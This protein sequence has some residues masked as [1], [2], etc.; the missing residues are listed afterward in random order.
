[1]K[2]FFLG[3]FLV[4]M[5][6]YLCAQT[7]FTTVSDGDWE[8]CSTWGT[9]PGTTAGIHYPSRTDDVVLSFK[10]T[11]SSTTDNGSAAA[12]PNDLGLSNVCDGCTT[13]NVP[14]GCNSNSFYQD[15]KITINSGGEFESSVKLIFTDT[16]QVNSG[17]ILDINDDVFVIGFINAVSGADIDFGDDLVI[18]GDG[19]V[20]S[21]VSYS[22][23]DDIYIDGDGAAICGSGTATLQNLG[24]GGGAEIQTFYISD[25]TALD[26]ICSETTIICA[27][28][29]CCEGNCSSDLETSGNDGEISPAEGGGDSDEILPIELL[30]FSGES[31]E[32]GTLLRW[33]TATEINNDFF[34][35][36]RSTNGTAY[37]PIKKIKGSGSTKNITEYSYL[38]MS[39][40]YFDF[41]FRLEQVD[42]DGNSE[43]FEPI[44]VKGNAV[45]NF[46]IQLRGN[47]VTES[48]KF[49]L[50]YNSLTQIEISII[51][52][53]GRTILRKY[54]D[55]QP[56]IELPLESF[57]L[58]G[59]YILR[60]VQGTKIVSER[61]TMKIF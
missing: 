27:D 26:Q 15:G 11:V 60:V 47:P 51:D 3:L 5:A 33:V 59:T 57:S 9:C 12:K 4:M 28:G 61:I 54:L 36:S 44:Y 40:G 23:A 14:G 35:L 55:P 7:T 41:F 39:G 6:N 49:R 52:L 16:V 30:S 10:V 24:G 17:G 21:D 58:T 34:I 53:A 20:N 43:I 8:D 38:D 19:V 2:H 1:M 31:V 25:D 13:C 37:D 29:D 46:N 56:F 42:F 18:S 22:V 48:L 50:D 32:N 45:Q